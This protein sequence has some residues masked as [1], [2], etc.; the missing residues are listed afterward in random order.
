MMDQNG[1]GPQPPRYF[2]DLEGP[3]ARRRSLP[4]MIASRRGYKYQGAEP[5]ETLLTAD[6]RELIRQIVED[7]AQDPDY[8]LP[9]TPLK[10]AIF[11]VLL[12]NGNQPMTA[13][14]ISQKLSQRWAMTANPRDIS[15]RVI[16]RLLDHS[17]SYCITR[18]PEPAPES[19]GNKNETPDQ[20]PSQT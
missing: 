5:V 17:E 18:V 7:S 2:I 13:E 9:D 10:E 1:K 6:P 11:R 19:N 8:L 3:C 16:Q 20:S 4:V 14:E 12:A 15:P